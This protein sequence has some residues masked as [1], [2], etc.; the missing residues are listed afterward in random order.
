MLLHNANTHNNIDV[1]IPRATLFYYL[2]TNALYYVN[3]IMPTS[4]TNKGTT[5]NAPLL[6]GTVAFRKSLFNHP[7]IYPHTSIDEDHAFIAC[8]TTNNALN[9]QIIPSH[10]IIIRHYAN[11]WTNINLNTIATPIYN[12]Y[13]NHSLLISISTEEDNNCIIVIVM[14]IIIIT[15]TTTIIY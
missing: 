14:I 8:I 9:I 12:N 15:T 1:V 5:E 11:T 7:C 6:L 2:Q 10:E 3:N 13:S 4:T